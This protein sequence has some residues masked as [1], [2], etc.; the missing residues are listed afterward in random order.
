MLQ[1]ALLLMD[2]FILVYIFLAVAFVVECVLVKY[3]KKVFSTYNLLTLN[4][5]KKNIIK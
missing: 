1:K 5:S 3:K 2:V 4:D